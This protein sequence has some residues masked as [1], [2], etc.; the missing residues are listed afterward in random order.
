MAFISA[1]FVEPWRTQIYVT[2][3]YPIKYDLFM[4]DL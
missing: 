4:D 3:L 2:G 1:R